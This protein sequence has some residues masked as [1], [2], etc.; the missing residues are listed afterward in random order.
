[1][2]DKGRTRKGAFAVCAAVFITSAA[3]QQQPSVRTGVTVV[4]VD[5]RVVDGLGNPI[6]DLTQAD[7][8]V[9]EDGRRQSVSHSPDGISPARLP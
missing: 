4:P 2:N 6:A 3:A 1:M 9:Y 8:E 5:V 7:F